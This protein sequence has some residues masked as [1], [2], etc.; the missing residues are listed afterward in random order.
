[1]PDG[2]G[3]LVADGRQHRKTDFS[4]SDHSEVRESRSDFRQHRAWYAKEIAQ[5]VIPRQG[6]KIHQQHSAGLGVVGE[7]RGPTGKLPEQE[8]VDRSA[9]NIS[10][11]RASLSAGKA[12][13][14]PS[15]LRRRVVRAERQSGR[16][17]D[18]RCVRR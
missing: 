9:Q 11:F 3:L 1:L 18:T 8:G 12:V 6:P 10:L 17:L 13:E 2:G 16:P 15:N 5:S 14:Q 7:V 4:R